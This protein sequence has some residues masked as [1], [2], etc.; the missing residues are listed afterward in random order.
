MIHIQEHYDVIIVGAGPA[1]L[2]A[3]YELVKQKPALKICLIDKGN[4][5]KQRKRTEVMCGVGGAGT[6]SDGKLH[7]TPVLS[8]EKILHLYSTEEIQ[9]YL[10]YVDKIFTDFGVDA[11]FSPTKMDEVHK[12]VDECTRN[13]VMLFI[14]KA[15]H[16]G[17]D[18]LPKIIEHFEDFLLKN[19]VV[20]KTNMEVQDF[21][22][23]NQVCTGVITD[24]GAI[25]GTY[26]I[27]AP[28]RYNARWMQKLADKYGLG[29]TYEKV[30]VGVRVEFH[31]A[32]MKRHF[33][34][35]HESIFHI[36]TPTFDDVVRTFCPCPNGM[37][38]L[39][40]YDDFI[41]VNGHS[42]SKMESENSNFAL[43]T[44]VNLTEPVENTIK[45]G[46]SIAKLATTIGGGKPILQRLR[47]LK[48]GRRSTWER[49][50][51]SHIKP[52][53]TDVTPGDISMALPHRVVTNLLEGL[54]MLEKVIPGIN[55]DSTLLYAPEIKLRSSKIK[56][57]KYL[58]TKVKNLFVAGD[59]S[60]L[61][62]NIVG[63]ATTGII[64]AQGII[65]KYST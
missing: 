30:E 4:S 62:G 3:A 59:G 21:I 9:N 2:F 52:T 54:E 45:Y 18:K 7:Y 12:L 28:G 24:K 16:V 50:N 20:L 15:R 42:D 40:Q 6:F 25:T 51:K 8:H 34:I 33:D 14:R 13:G 10:N 65:K 11:P 43:V 31:A 26:I 1:G 17:S 63:A 56:T 48:K 32:I 55:S 44:E 36:H 49:I 47:D 38:A 35:M 41:C 5:I 22:I 64:A 27:S 53:L 19:K 58:E 39:E 60:G 61:S 23:S 57:D 37:V 29:F 46:K